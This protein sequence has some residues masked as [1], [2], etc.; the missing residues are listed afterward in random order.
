MLADISSDIHM[1]LRI[2]K[3]LIVLISLT[4]LSIFLL[5]FCWIFFVGEEDQ[6]Q[7]EKLYLVEDW[8]S[9]MF[10]LPFVVL[11][12]IYLMRAKYLNFSIFKLLLGLTAI[13][14]FGVSF[15]SSAMLAQDYQAS[16]G[17]FLSLCLFPLIVAFLI[18]QSILAKA[19]RNGS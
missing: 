12:G 11:W 18:N 6:G 7:W 9:L 8:M 4:S 19:K 13:I 15:L 16:W 3:I 17:V 10:Y 5:P 2:D 14:T 1:N